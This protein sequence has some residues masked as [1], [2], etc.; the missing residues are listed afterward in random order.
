M[1]LFS[2]IGDRIASRARV[3][4][5]A[6]Q[7]TYTTID[8]AELYTSR[9]KCLRKNKRTGIARRASRPS[10]AILYFH[11]NC[12]EFAIFVVKRKATIQIEAERRRGV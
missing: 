4:C 10:Y 8:R 3:S 11:G 1:S 9:S 12:I 6:G 7:C 2:A 5:H